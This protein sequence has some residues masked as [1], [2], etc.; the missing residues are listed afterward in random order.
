MWLQTANIPRYQ[1]SVECQ[2][3]G[4]IQRECE[5]AKNSWEIASQL[6][7][8]N[9]GQSS[10]EIETSPPELQLPEEYIAIKYA[11]QERKY[12]MTLVDNTYLF[13]CLFCSSHSTTGRTV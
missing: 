12:K 6:A 7:K 4:D 8:G 11:N 13:P 9:L 10:G 1:L 5:P 2:I 3:P